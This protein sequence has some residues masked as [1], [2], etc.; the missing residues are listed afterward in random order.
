MNTKKMINAVLLA[1][2]LAGCSDTAVY[3][4]GTYTGS[5]DGFNGELQVEVTVKDGSIYN[6]EVVQHVE[7]DGQADK[8][9]E[10]IPQA[11]AEANKADY[12]VIEPDAVS[13]C[14][15]TAEAIVDACRDALSKAQ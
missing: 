10:L 14:T 6:V 7:S 4:D 9:L 13:G 12:S 11:I 2:M 1:A 5:A 3:K 15:D 8:A